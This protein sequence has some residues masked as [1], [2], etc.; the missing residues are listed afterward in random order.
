MT[1]CGRKRIEIESVHAFILE[2]IDFDTDDDKDGQHAKD[3]S[4]F[5][6]LLIGVYLE[7]THHT[8]GAAKDFS[9]ER[10]WNA[11][12]METLTV[13]YGR[14]KP[15]LLLIA[16]DKMVQNKNTRVQGLSL[17]SVFARHQTPHLYTVSQTP[18]IEHLI[19][20]LMT[21]TS[22]VSVQ[23]TLTTLIMF[24]PHIPSYILQHLSRLFL[25][26]SRLL[27]WD[28]I[29]P[30]QGSHDNEDASQK[31]DDQT[32]KP[33]EKPAPEPQ[34]GLWEKLES[35]PDSEE[36]ST[37]DLGFFFTFLYGLYPLNFT[38]YIRKPR[39]YLKDRN[40]PRAEELDTDQDL[41]RA[42][43]E[44]FRKGHLLHPNF[45]MT[46]AEDELKDEKWL[47]SDPADVVAECISLRHSLY[48]NL[49]SPGP[50]PSSKLPDVPDSPIIRAD[51]IPSDSLLHRDD[52]DSTIA[53]SVT[54]LSKATLHSPSSSDQKKPSRTGS[55]GRPRTPVT[56]SPAASPLARS[57]Q[58]T[59]DSPTLPAFPI[60]PKT[61][62]A[63]TPRRGSHGSSAAGGPT[64]ADKWTHP[65]TAMFMVPDS[66]KKVPILRQLTLTKNELNFERYL[67]QQHLA[68]I[69][70]LQ[71]RH[72][73][74]ATLHANTENLMNTNKSLK[75]KLAKAN[76]A[77][78][79]LKKETAT[80]RTQT[81]Q[82]EVDLTSRVRGLKESE[83]VWHEERE[84]LRVELAKATRDCDALRNIV[85]NTESR[86]LLAKQEVASK[87]I[88]LEQIDDLQLRIR[89]LEGKVKDLEKRNND[90]QSAAD[91]RDILK[92]EKATAELMYKSKEGEYE[93]T[94]KAFE[95]RVATLEQELSERPDEPIPEQI[96]AF[97]NAMTAAQ[98][99]Y[100]KLQKDYA[101]LKHTHVEL[102]IRCQELEGELEAKAPG[103]VPTRSKP[104][105]PPRPTR[106]DSFGSDDFPGQTSGYDSSNSHGGSPMPFHST[107]NISSQEGGVSLSVSSPSTPPRHMPPLAHI[108][109]T[110][111]GTSAPGSSTGGGGPYKHSKSAFSAE[112]LDSGTG[113]ATSKK[114]KIKAQSEKRVYGRGM[115]ALDDTPDPDPED[116][117]EDDDVPL[118]SRRD[119]QMSSSSV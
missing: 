92:M 21:D 38:S 9:P 75:A 96:S 51:D 105:I 36:S 76:E 4:A 116:E 94:R 77:Y 11:D 33:E 71:R 85:V 65:S 113:S 17:L 79:A 74:D 12:Q 52:E 108:N 103:S 5:V 82:F 63:D 40:F 86:E 73:N 15:K 68:H 8:S 112:S 41:I 37:L 110:A 55:T 53:N 42:R 107:P 1:S 26:Y 118:L 90:L 83:R 46:T 10:E 54:S 84:S 89:E 61:P 70:Q 24:L 66:I 117:E 27:C 30:P 81:K 50:P 114:D 48:P 56:P 93:R 69:G 19:Q 6:D 28:Q 102:E 20:C 45:Y 14:K 97:Q 95:R 44:S 18:L 72:I 22:S 13:D 88:E 109:T 32:A 59:A 39:R 16:L 25:I 80:G 101:K 106:P 67:K 99:R 98:N 115:S 100:K 3:S 119:S 58:E 35:A 2:S 57:R 34:P 47:K 78:A 43:T 111:S 23:L 62:A 60:P 64:S 87:N 7:L 31:K 49:E 91:E 29:H 104:T